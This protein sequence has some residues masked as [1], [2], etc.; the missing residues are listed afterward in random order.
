VHAG[1]QIV[2][3]RLVAGGSGEVQREVARQQLAGEGVDVDQFVV[4]PAGRDGLR[5]AEA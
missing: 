1:V 5:A 2:I 3:Q 4:A